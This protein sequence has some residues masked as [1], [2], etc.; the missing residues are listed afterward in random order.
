MVRQR[1]SIREDLEVSAASN[2][3]SLFAFFPSPTCHLCFS[4]TFRRLRKA[5]DFYCF[6]GLIASSCFPVLSSLILLRGL[7]APHMTAQLLPFPYGAAPSAPSAWAGILPGKCS[8][9]DVSAGEAAP[10]LNSSPFNPSRSSQV[11]NV[12]F[13]LVVC[14][15]PSAGAGLVEGQA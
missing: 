11:R 13:S 14:V 2:G 6:F 1:R 3:R 10:F 12:Y 7:P 4:F 9:P 5:G 8:H 15:S